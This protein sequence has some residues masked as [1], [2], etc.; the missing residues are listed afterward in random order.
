V[1]IW[2]PEAVT[3]RGEVVAYDGASFQALQDTAQAPGGSDWICL[4]T[5]GRDGK[6]PHVRGTFKPDEQYAELDIVAHN[7]GSFIAKCDNPGPCPGDGWKS[8]TMPGKKGDRGPAGPRGEA[9]PHG[10]GGSPALRAPSSPPG[11]ST[12]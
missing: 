1:K 10:P 8:L 5:A 3:Y 11:K 4:A 6:S 9:G 7:G 2:R 12:K